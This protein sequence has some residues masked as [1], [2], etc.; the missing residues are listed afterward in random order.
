[1]ITRIL[2]IALS[3]AADALRRKIVYVVVLFAAVMAAAIPS[4][5]SYGVGVVEAVYREVALT[6]T[7][8]AT[9]VVVL[10]LSANRVPSEVEHRTV[11]NVL[12]RDVRR[13]EYVVGTWLGIALTTAGVVGAFLLIDL[14][15]GWAV[16]G[17]PMW[18]LWQ[19]AVS[20]W[21]EA[22][23]VAAF[24]VTV[25]TV[26]GPV[27]VAVSSLAFLFIAHVRSGLFE[28]GS[29]G[30]VLYPSLDSFN[31]INPVAH[32][33]GVSAGYLL[34]MLGVFLAWIAALLL[35]GVLAF[36]RRDL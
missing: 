29:P 23:I 19:G 3:V 26:A 7:Y 8:V 9:M 33:S 10:A 11:Y 15:V 6:V 30:Y 22:A 14:A 36:D 28:A 24:S 1:V 31:I 4:L 35:L 13:W 16:Y 27:V 2:P 12:S 34:T 5:P 32:G 20:I 25:S 18:Q 17:M 21:F